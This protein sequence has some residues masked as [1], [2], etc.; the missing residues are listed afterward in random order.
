MLGA[1]R[2]TG[3]D[4]GFGSTGAQ[5]QRPRAAL[6][7]RARVEHAC[8]L[9]HSLPTSCSAPGSGFVAGF[10]ASI[11][12]RTRSETSAV[13]QRRAC[14]LDPFS[15]LT[16]SIQGSRILTRA[17]SRRAQLRSPTAC[18]LLGGLCAQTHSALAQA[19]GGPLGGEGG[20]RGPPAAPTTACLAS[21]LAGLFAERRQLR[22]ALAELDAFCCQGGAPRC[23]TLGRPPALSF[24]V[25]LLPPGRCKLPARCCVF[26][27]S[28]ARA[29]AACSSILR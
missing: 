1:C 10:V 15:T 18:K 17:P 4:G 25:S 14:A 27:L 12:W 28:A 24:P 21:L 22:A 7:T 8:F 13:R 19:L 3:T 29:G 6:I 20:C 9:I 11:G 5:L 2:L 26:V 16:V 23:R